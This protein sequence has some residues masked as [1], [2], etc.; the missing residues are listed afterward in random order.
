MNCNQRS[1]TQPRALPLTVLMD[2]QE[3]VMK[4]VLPIDPELDPVGMDAE[5]APLLRPRHL[6]WVL[7]VEFPEPF[8][9]LLPARKGP[10]LFGDRCTNLAAPRPGVEVRVHIGRI[11]F[12]DTPFDPDLPAQRLPVKK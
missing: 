11:H 6:C 7:L 3:P 10:A 4:P 9:Q 2:K 5:P 12:S 8:F 1:R